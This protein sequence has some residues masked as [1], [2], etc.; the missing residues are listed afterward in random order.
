M[1]WCTFGLA[2]RYTMNTHCGWKSLCC[3][4]PFCTDYGRGFAVYIDTLMYPIYVFEIRI[5][6]SFFKGGHWGSLQVGWGYQCPSGKQEL[7][8]RN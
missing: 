6:D 3:F 2:A 1:S 5:F 8:R 4:N 7:D